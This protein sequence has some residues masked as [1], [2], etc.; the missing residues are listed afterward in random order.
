MKNTTCHFIIKTVTNLNVASFRI[1]EDAHILFDLN[2]NTTQIDCLFS[3][4]EKQ[5]YLPQP[6][7]FNYDIATL[8]D[9]SY[10]VKKNSKQTELSH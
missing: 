7:M 8:R 6:L 1:K 10:Y 3:V 5:Y 2:L 4:L 9:L